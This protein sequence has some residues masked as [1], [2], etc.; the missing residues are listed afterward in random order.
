MHH[1]AENAPLFSAVQRAVI[2]YAR[3]DLE[4]AH[5]QDLAQM[6]AARL[7]LLVERLRIRLD[8]VLEVIDEASER[9][10]AV[11]DTSNH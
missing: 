6:P 9:P 11:T 8:A 2:D 4:S 5:A 10:S 1:H 3:R 7:V